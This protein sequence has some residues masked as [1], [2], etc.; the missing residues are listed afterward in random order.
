[1]VCVSALHLEAEP[2]LSQIE[3]WHII[4]IIDDTLQLN[5]LMKDSILDVKDFI[6]FLWKNEGWLRKYNHRSYIEEMDERSLYARIS[7]GT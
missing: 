6:L 3:E 1:M 7:K 4:S 2:F 5:G